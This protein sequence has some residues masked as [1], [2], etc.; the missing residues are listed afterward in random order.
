MA[1]KVKNLRD[2]GGIPAEDGK[3]IKPGLLYRSAYLCK[4]PSERAEHFCGNRNIS[5]VIDLRSPSELADNAENLPSDVK[6]IHL[7][8]LNDSQNPSINKENRLPVL[9]SIM[10]KE[11]GARKYLSDTYRV[12][13]T[14]EQ[15]LE[16]FENL[17]RLLL[18]EKDGAVL[19]HCTQGKDRTGI[20]A[21]T[22]LMALGVDREEIMR[23]YMRT[24]RSCRIKNAL[25]YLGVTLVTLSVHKAHSLNLL[26][27]SKKYYM[28]AAFDEIDRSFGGTE[29]FLKQGLGLSDEDITN[30]RSIY[31]S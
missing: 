31:L 8:P 11:G 23:D 18:E 7:P 15:S 30:L 10:K 6:Y 1:K 9:K 21:A 14:Q 24:N 12:M 20:A 29:G 13:V 28:Q 3:R 2:L 27:T 26:L 25:I 22:V 17:I 4:L 16:A 19:W 5:A